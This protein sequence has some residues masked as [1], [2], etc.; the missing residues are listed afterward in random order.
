MTIAA[1]TWVKFTADGR[2]RSISKEGSRS[3]SGLHEGLLI[4]EQERAIVTQTAGADSYIIFFPEK[5]MIGWCY[6]H[7]CY[8]ENP[9]QPLAKINFVKVGG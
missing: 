4:G 2:L 5:N 8:V 1:G 9:R 6:A 3:Q 7:E